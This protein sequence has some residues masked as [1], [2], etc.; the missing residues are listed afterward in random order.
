MKSILLFIFSVPMVLNAKIGET[1][2]QCHV[3]YGEIVD[4]GMRRNEYEKGAV[5]S[6]CW[7]S[8][9]KCVAVT[10]RI[11]PFGAASEVK[12]D[13]LLNEDQA[14]RLL[15]LNNGGAKWVKQSDLDF[16]VKWG[17]IFKTDDGRLQAKISAL[18][19][20]IE[21]T[22]R[23]K[24]FASVVRTEAVDAVIKSFSS[25]PPGK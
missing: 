24:E 1:P 23:Q 15:E 8:K 18:S 4:N 19:V 9:G 5:R 14:L 16:G 10:Y 6:I 2:E 11:S 13:V 17:G 3:R 20:N 22:E 12:D 7:F 21:T 25:D